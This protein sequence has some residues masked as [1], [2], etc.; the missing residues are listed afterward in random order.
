MFSDVTWKPRIHLMTSI[1]SSF[2]SSVPLNRLLLCS[3]VPA[4]ALFLSTYCCAVP[5]YRLLLCS[6]VPIVALFLST[7]CCSVPLYRLLL[8]SS[9]PLSLCFSVR[10][11]VPLYLR[12]VVPP[13]L[14]SS[15]VFSF[16]PTVFVFWIR[17]LMTSVRSSYMSHEPKCCHQSVMK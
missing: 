10:S 6:S 9:V 12:A 15:V 7:D 16:V 13:F 2:C 4:V 11:S 5:L 3:S 1:R 8:C 17:H 14:S